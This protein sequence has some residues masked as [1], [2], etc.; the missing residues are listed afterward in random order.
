MSK[1]PPTWLPASIPPA[2]PGP[3]RTTAEPGC[4]VWWRWWNGRAWGKCC[5]SRVLAVKNQVSVGDGGPE[6]WSAT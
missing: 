4:S 1:N 2:N 5:K 6:L 3:F